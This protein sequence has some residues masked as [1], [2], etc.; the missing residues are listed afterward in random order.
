MTVE[1]E[2]ISQVLRSLGFHEK[3]INLIMQCITSVSYKFL[4]NDNIY[5]GI[6]PHRGIRQGDP[7]SP[8][9]FILCGEVLSN[10]CKKASSEGSLRGIRV[11]RGSPRVN[12]LL[13]A[14][15]TMIFCQSAPESCKA[16]MHIL[17]TYEDASGQKINI[18]KSSVTFSKKTL[19]EVK[20]SVKQI[21]GISKEGGV[22]KYLGLPEHFGRRKRDLFTS[23]VDRIRQRASN[24][25]T[26]FLSKAGKL[27]MLKAVLTA[28]PSYMMSCFQLPVNSARESKV[29]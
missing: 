12:H 19:Q 11:A 3:W 8:Y 6:I 7:I 2:F 4:I 26:R 16:L 14:D 5:G 21:L 10:L 23:I 29:R 1:W 22:G 13:F 9:I 24:W 27:T 25:S 28:I 18:A 15:N 17:Q 20:N